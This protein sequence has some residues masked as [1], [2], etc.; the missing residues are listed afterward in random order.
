[1]VSMRALAG[2]SKDNVAVVVEDV[3]AGDQ[4]KVEGKQKRLTID[5]IEKIPF[6]F[7]VAL[8]NLP[9]GSDIVRYGEIIG[10]ATVDIKKGAQVH[11]HN[12]DGIRVQV[13][14]GDK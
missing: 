13:G 2:N 5:A 4:V 10:R 11:V 12:I 9:E 14:G 6:G 3:I 8:E 7:K 1:M